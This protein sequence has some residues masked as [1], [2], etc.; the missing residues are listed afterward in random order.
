MIAFLLILGGA[1]FGVL[2]TLHAT[3]CSIC[4]TRDDLSL[5]ILRLRTRWR[6][7]RLGYRED[8]RTCGELGLASTLATVLA[9]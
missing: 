8:A 5:P 4:A 9:C 2:G 1:V 3:L 7:R 6:I